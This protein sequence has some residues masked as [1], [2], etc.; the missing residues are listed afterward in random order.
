[1][2]QRI[3]TLDDFVNESMVYTKLDGFAYSLVSKKSRMIELDVILDFNKLGYKRSDIQIFLDNGWRLDLLND[4]MKILQ[5][6]KIIMN[7]DDWTAD[8]SELNITSSGL[9]GKLYIENV[10]F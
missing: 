4:I 8:P 3:P 10:A 7:E 6:D 9:K 1:M 5:S 2:K